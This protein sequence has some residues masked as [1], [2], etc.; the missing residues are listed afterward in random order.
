MTKPVYLWAAIAT[1]VPLG[2]S[3]YAGFRRDARAATETDY[4]ISGQTVSADD[5]ANTSVGYALQMAAV[6]LFADWGAH[7][8]LGALWAPAFWCLGFG[9]LYWLLPKFLPYREKD[10]PMTLHEYLARSVGGSRRVQIV[11]SLA[12]VLGLAGTLMNEVDYTLA[13]YQPVVGSGRWALALS[14]VFLLVGMSYV[15]A[16]GFKAEVVAERVQMRIAYI[17]VVSALV[18]SL[19]FVWHRATPETYR[20][21]ELGLLVTLGLMAAAKVNVRGRPRTLKALFPDTQILIPVAGAAVVVWQR[22]YLQLLPRGS[23][24]SVLET[25]IAGQLSAQGWLGVF[26]LLVANALW[27]PV[28][29]A[30]WQRVEAVDGSDGRA[31]ERLR[32]GTLRV[33]IESPAS[34]GLGVVLGWML[35]AGGFVPASGDTSQALAAYATALAD[36]SRTADVPWGG[37]LVYVPL[38]AGCVAVMLSTISG[39]LTAIGYTAYRDLLPSRERT[40]G[41]ARIWTVGILLVSWVGFEGLRRVAGANLATLL[42]GAYAMQLALFVTV[43]ITLRRARGSEPGAFASVCFGIAA[44]LVCTGFA[45]YTQAEALYVLPPVLAVAFAAVAYVFGH[46]LERSSD[47]EPG[48]PGHARALPGTEHGAPQPAPGAGA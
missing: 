6:F 11:A 4:L 35:N 21:V 16:H 22:Q 12:T 9:L 44:S 26:S 24:A 39:L 5:Y 29:L 45:A 37:L 31:L 40:I 1:A 13:V 7:Y 30:T 42:Y 48:P 46:A 36:G 14:A 20:H 10:T 3:V 27:M 17:G 43:I 41:R 33:L 23:V 8:G 28:D 25:P 2:L 15:L 19:A 34:W 18:L 47:A 32:A 38:V